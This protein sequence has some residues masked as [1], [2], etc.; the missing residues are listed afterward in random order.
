MADP[1]PPPRKK[2]VHMYGTY[3]TILKLTD[4]ALS[5]MCQTRKTPTLTRLKILPVLTREPYTSL[6]HF[7]LKLGKTR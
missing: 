3:H 1:P 6:L 5:K 7:L 2:H 4:H